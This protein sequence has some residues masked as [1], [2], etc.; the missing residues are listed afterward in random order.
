MTSFRL[1]IA[2]VIAFTLQVN[3]NPIYT[4]LLNELQFTGSTWILELHGNGQSLDGWSLQSRS[5]SAF[6]KIGIQLNP[7][8]YQ[9]ITSDSLLTP[10]SIDQEGDS[11][12][13]YS[14]VAVEGR[15]V[16]GNSAFAGIAAPQPGQSICFK[17]AAPSYY[18]LDNS[19]TPGQVNDSTNAMGTMEG[20][21]RDSNGQ[22][23]QGARIYSSE[24][25]AGS[26]IQTDSNGRF[27]IHSYA[28]QMYLTFTHPDCMN[29]DNAIQIWP[30]ST[31][32]VNI[33]L[34]RVSSVDERPDPLKNITLNQNFPNPFNPVT[35][36][37]FTIPNAMFVMTK[38][39]DV[40][41]REVGTLMSE[42]LLAGPHSATWDASH[43]ASG[44]YFARVFA[45]NQVRTLR[46]ILLR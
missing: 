21:V 13:L 40:Y 39:Y 11:L 35:T 38:I 3:A 45:G 16:F 17:E 30:E 14:G 46:M 6:F 42:Q 28:H 37:S 36:I 22:V 31:T 33:V 5:G 4:S 43:V 25:P 10:L 44:V 8:T 2:I 24:W 1:F 27:L 9:L 20:I 29:R 12:I 23:L 32:T 7:N 18:Y 19:P 41:G 15:L 26:Y 34:N